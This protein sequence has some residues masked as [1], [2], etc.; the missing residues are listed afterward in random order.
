M[1][2]K[3]DLKYILELI[4]D[5][6]SEVKNEISSQFE[7]YS[8][9]LEEDVISILGY[10]PS[11]ILE[12]LEPFIELNRRKLLVDGLKNIPTE[13]NEYQ[14]LEAMMDLIDDYQLGYMN[15]KHLLK[16]YLDQFAEDFKLLYTD[17]NAFNLEF[18]CLN[19]VNLVE[20]HMIFII[21]IIEIL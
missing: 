11:N 5:Q 10:V 1:I 3:N 2:Y 21:P 19:I 7:N 14:Q 20:T 12:T 4:D 9:K 16:I 15:N 6:D 13:I 8:G 17:V 18:I